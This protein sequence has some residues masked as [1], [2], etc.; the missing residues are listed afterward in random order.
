MLKILINSYTCCPGKGSEQG[1]GWNW[2]TSLAKTGEVELFV[3]SE[4]EYASKVLETLENEKRK[5]KSEKPACDEYS[6]AERI[7]FYWNPVDQATRE[8]CWNQGNWAFYPLYAEWQKKT[9][10]IA[11]EIIKE[12]ESKGERIDILH[13]LNMIGFREPGYLHEVSKNTGIPLIWGPVDAKGSFPIAY[14]AGASIKVKTFL[15]IKNLINWMQLKWMPRVHAVAKQATFVISASSNSKKSFAEYFNIDSPLINETGCNPS[16]L[17]AKSE[18]RR[19][20]NDNSTLEILWVGKMDFRKQLGLALETIA[21]TRVDNVKLHIV[22]GGDEEPYKCQAE[23]LGVSENIIWHG[24][25]SH[26]EVL[27]MMQEWDLLLFTSV[28]EGTP[29]VV[30]EAMANGL[31]VVC[32]DTCGHGDSV[33]D[34]CGVKIPVK[35]PKESVKRFSE[36]IIDLYNNREKLADMSQNCKK[37]AEELSWE[38]KAKELL[39]LYTMTDE[40]RRKVNISMM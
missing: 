14:T 9:A 31:P 30:L 29:H 23:K 6:W 35:N 26:D 39:R 37:R 15:R 7:H 12:L 40:K 21:K 20:K 25:V 11:R 18:K 36:I 4:G 27:Q 2:I 10:E 5:M 34:D 24:S 32:H 28:A 13:Q 1:M 17:E 3:I 8:K 19:V 33:T 16:S 22:G 38:N